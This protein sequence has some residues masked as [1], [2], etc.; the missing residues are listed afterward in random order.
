MLHI[1][2]KCIP[3][4]IMQWINWVFCKHF[5]TNK[6]IKVYTKRQDNHLYYINMVLYF[7]LKYTLLFFF[8]KWCSTV[9]DKCLTG[10]SWNRRWNLHERIGKLQFFICWYLHFI[11]TPGVSGAMPNQ[12]SPPSEDLL[13]PSSQLA[14][15]SLIRRIFFPW[16]QPRRLMYRG[17]PKHYWGHWRSGRRQNPP[18]SRREDQQPGRG[19]CLKETTHS[20]S[21]PASDTHRWKDHVWGGL[22]CYGTNKFSIVSAWK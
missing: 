7:I 5:H 10:H 12:A 22:M 1:V 21:T 6:D 9:K 15:T 4:C 18:C 20:R 19:H 3:L 17:T 11:M 13:Q 2:Y 16:R 8:T 14:W